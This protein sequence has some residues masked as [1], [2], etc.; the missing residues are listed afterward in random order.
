M[1]RSTVSALTFALTAALGLSAVPAQAKAAVAKEQAE[2]NTSSG[3]PG[4]PQSREVKYCFVDTVTG[5]HIRTKICK[6]RKEWAR[7]GVDVSKP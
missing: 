1:K 5:T 2:S 4:V 3:S 6:T 7:E